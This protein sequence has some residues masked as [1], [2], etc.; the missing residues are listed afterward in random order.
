MMDID[1]LLGPLPGEEIIET[2]TTE[3]STTADSYSSWSPFGDPSVEG[4]GWLGWFLPQPG[5]APL[6]ELPDVNVNT[7]PIAIAVALVGL[8]AVGVYAATRRN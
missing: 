5:S 6:V 3:I 4:D 7:T 8:S 2:A 1:P